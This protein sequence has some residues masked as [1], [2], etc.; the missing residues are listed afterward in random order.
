MK[1]NN[2]LQEKEQIPE[3]SRFHWRS[4]I[5]FTKTQLVHLS[6]ICRLYKLRVLAVS[7]K[8]PLTASHAGPGILLPS[9][10]ERP[11]V[12]AA[13]LRDRAGGERHTRLS[14]CWEPLANVRGPTGKHTGLLGQ[15]PWLCAR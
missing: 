1:I 3:R 6:E 14:L 5:P 12:V 8:G 15:D 7:E 11:R 2:K 4:T 13:A 9:T 10:Q